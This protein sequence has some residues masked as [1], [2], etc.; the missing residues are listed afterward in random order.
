MEAQQQIQHSAFTRA[1]QTYK[2]CCC[3]GR[4]LKRQTFQCSRRATAPRVGEA[5]LFEV[6]PPLHMRQHRLSDIEAKEPRIFVLIARTSVEQSED[7]PCHTLCSGYFYQRFWQGR[8]RRGED[9]HHQK[10]AC[11]EHATCHTTGEGR[12]LL[13]TPCLVAVDDKECCR[14]AADRNSTQVGHLGRA[15]SECEDQSRSN[16]LRLDRGQASIVTSDLL[17]LPIEGGHG[18]YHGDG[19]TGHAPRFRVGNVL[20]MDGVGPCGL[21]AGEAKPGDWKASK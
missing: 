20:H 9:A 1:T 3:A 14:V 5:D 8:Q 15:N 19:R 10:D 21:A 17:L 4:N 7:A 18:A 16:T 2:G 6:H 13:P 11:D 12:P